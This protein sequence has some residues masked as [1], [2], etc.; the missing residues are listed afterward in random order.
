MVSF[1]TEDFYKKKLRPICGHVKRRKQMIT[2]SAANGLEIPYLGCLEL[3]I[4]VDGGES[5]QLRGT[6][7]ERQHSHFL[8]EKGRTW[9][10]QNQFSGADSQ[11]W[12]PAPTKD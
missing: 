3:E 6:C 10:P 12:C 9:T 7:P 2:L 5:A 8:T 1:V 11:V 4:E